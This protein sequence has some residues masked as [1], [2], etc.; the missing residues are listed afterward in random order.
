[1]MTALA[2]PQGKLATPRD[3]DPRGQVFSFS[4]RFCKTRAHYSFCARY[5]SLGSAIQIMFCLTHTAKTSHYPVCCRLALARQHYLDTTTGTRPSVAS[6][7]ATAFKKAR[8][9]PF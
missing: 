3:S 4:V 6:I 1:M 2:C 9:G 5:R 7:E 8:S